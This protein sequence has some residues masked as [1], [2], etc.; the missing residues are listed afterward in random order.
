MAQ[1]S[2]TA[3]L[4]DESAETWSGGASDKADA[5]SKTV[6]YF[7]DS[8]SG[9]LIG[10]TA[11]ERDEANAESPLRPEEVPPEGS[12]LYEATQQTGRNQAR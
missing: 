10:L 8:E 6:A 5:L 9:S 12:F 2:V 4:H 11:I 7:E 3:Y 1:W